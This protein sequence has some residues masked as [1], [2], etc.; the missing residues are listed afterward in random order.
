[1]KV[2][3]KDGRLF[4]NL[5]DNPIV[6]NK[7]DLKPVSRGKYFPHTVYFLSSSRLPQVP[8]YVGETRVTLKKRL[9]GHIT[10]SLNENNSKYKYAISSWI[11]ETRSGGFDI[12]ISEIEGSIFGKAAAVRHEIY[13]TEKFIEM[14][15]KMIFNKLGDNRKAV[16]ATCKFSGKDTYYE[17]LRA[18]ERITGVNNGNIVKACKNILATAGKRKWRYALDAETKQ[19]RQQQ[20]LKVAA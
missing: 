20:K 15:H 7:N 8:V 4:V 6:V 10:V 17:G 1:M 12:L 11:R 2:I 9:S 5:T 13:Y 3:F 19:Y 14:G 16:V 18:A